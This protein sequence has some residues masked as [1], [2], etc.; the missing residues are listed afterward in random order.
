LNVTLNVAPAPT[1]TRP[2]AEVFLA[3]VPAGIN[4]ADQKNAF[5]AA[6]TSFVAR[7]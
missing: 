5:I 4:P 6:G 1:M 7:P 3:Q 2:S